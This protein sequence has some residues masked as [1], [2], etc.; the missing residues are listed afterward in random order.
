MSLDLTNTI[1]YDLHFPSKA[2]VNA[3]IGAISEEAV[4]CCTPEKSRGEWITSVYMRSASGLVERPTT[5]LVKKITEEHGGYIGA[6]RAR[7]AL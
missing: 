2:G 5:V 3:A 6:W 1:I 7:Q 4:F